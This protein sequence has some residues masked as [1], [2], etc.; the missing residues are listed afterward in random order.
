M[1]AETLRLLLTVFLVA[2]YVLVMLYLR[3]RR[4]TLGQL[5]AW[6]LLALLVPAL[7]PFLIILFRPGSSGRIR[8]REVG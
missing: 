1:T 5:A 4:L 6:G 7:G 2:M 8:H 3:G